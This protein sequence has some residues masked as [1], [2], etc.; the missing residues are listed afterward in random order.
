VHGGG[1]GD[2]QA[3]GIVVLQVGGHLGDDVAV[4]RSVA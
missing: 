1:D 3:L 2:V 4:V